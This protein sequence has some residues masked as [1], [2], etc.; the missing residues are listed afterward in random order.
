MRA[1]CQFA[2]AGQG[3]FYNGLLVDQKGRSF[4]FVY[5]CGTSGAATVLKNSVLEYKELSGHRL[6]LLAISHFHQDHV[7]HIPELIDGL[8]L[9]TVVIPF[10]KP[11]LLLLLAAQYEEIENNDERIRLYSNPA[12]YFLAHGA[13]R[14]I[15]ASGDESD[16]EDINFFG[17]PSNDFPQNDGEDKENIN[18]IVLSVN[19]NTNT[20]NLFERGTVKYSGCFYA[21]AP[22]YQWEFRFKNLHYARIQDSFYVDI[23]KLLENNNNSFYEILRN[24]AYIKNLRD[25]YEKNFKGVLNDTSLI[26]LSRPLQ[27]GWLVDNPSHWCC[28]LDECVDC[29]DE[30]YDLWS[31][32]GQAST[33]LLGDLSIDNEVSHRLFQQLERQRSGLPRVIQL[34]HHGAK[35]KY[36]PFYCELFKDLKHRCHLPIS[37]IAS[38]GIKNKYGHPDL[39]GYTNYHLS[40]L[41][42]W[43]TNI[44]LVNER[45]DFT[46]TIAF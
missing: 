32:Y 46:Y 44:E 37:L 29:D 24:K 33:L 42:W 12:M 43:N 31:K 6:D 30:C 23:S 1:E 14:V 22:Y 20:A 3:L 11:E 25:I 36:H 5:D 41:F 15:V 19:K 16:N 27:R 21:S 4:S 28:T 35:M 40:D 10:V 39:S 2:K 45:K 9:G 34:P 13:E 38:Y 8:E 18:Q 26:L 17:E 7:S